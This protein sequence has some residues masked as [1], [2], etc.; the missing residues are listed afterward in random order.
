M[1]PLQPDG[2]LGAC[3]QLVKLPGTPHF[4]GRTNQ[5]DSSHPHD[6]QFDPSGRFVIVPD[7]GL[8]RVFVL[9]FDPAQGCL[10]LVEQGSPTTRAGAGPRHVAFHPSRPIAWVANELDSTVSTYRWDNR[11]GTLAPLNVISALPGDFNG[12]SIASEIAFVQAT[13]TLY[14]SNRGH[15]SI[16]MFQVNPKTGLIRPIGWEPCGGR[17]PRFFGIDPSGRFLFVANEQE[18][19]VV[20]FRMIAGSGQLRRTGRIVQTLSPVTIVFTSIAPSRARDLRVRR[21][22][23]CE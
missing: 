20:Q 18:D 9:R 5:Q 6:V 13:N 7:K 17:H 10:D 23:E 16:A 19:T 11:R 1:H 8:D 4:R 3:S 15:D 14:V 12:D 2:A 22:V 21:E